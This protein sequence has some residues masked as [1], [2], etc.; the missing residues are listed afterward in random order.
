MRPTTH[1]ACA[2]PPPH[3]CSVQAVTS[4]ERLDLRVASGPWLVMSRE[5]SLLALGR[6]AALWAFDSM[7]TTGRR[8][9]RMQSEWL[10]LDGESRGV[11]RKSLSWTS[12]PKDA[13]AASSSRPG[14]VVPASMLWR[15]CYLKVER[16]NGGGSDAG[17]ASH[18]E[19]DAVT[20]DLPKTCR[21][22]EHATWT[23][24]QMPVTPTM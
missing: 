18:G 12:Q 11:E 19:Q 3:H 13:Q 6:L 17:D 20:L 5:V 24:P 8:R 22:N 23:W 14:P 21:R 15:A 7:R 9:W 4:R 2:A 1:T 16:G 10:G